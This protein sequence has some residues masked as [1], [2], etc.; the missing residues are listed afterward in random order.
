MKHIIVSFCLKRQWNCTQV[1]TSS[2]PWVAVVVSEESNS[3]VTVFLQCLHFKS[4]GVSGVVLVFCRACRSRHSQLTN[5]PSAGCMPV[6][7]VLCQLFPLLATTFR[8]TVSMFANFM[9]LLLTSLK[10]SSWRPQ[11]LVPAASSPYRVVFGC[12][13]SCMRFACPSQ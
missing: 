6:L 1:L 8:F 9:F 11:Y 3:G 10:C 13:L 12:R 4:L 7:M 2:S 5:Q